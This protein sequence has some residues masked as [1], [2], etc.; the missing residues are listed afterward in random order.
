[1]TLP[2]QWLSNSSGVPGRAS[3]QAEKALHEF[4]RPHRL[5]QLRRALIFL[6]AVWAVLAITRLVW[7]LVP[8]GDLELDPSAVVV[9]PVREPAAAA[10]ASEVDIQQMISWQL[11]GEAGDEPLALVESEPE[12]AAA[13]REGIEEGARETRLELL[14]RGAVASTEDGR[15]HAIIE[16]RNTQ[17]VYAVEDKLP[18]SGNVVLAKVMPRQVVLDNGGTYEL[19]TLFEETTLDAQLP[20]ASQTAK[21]AQ[22]ATGAREEQRRDDPQTTAL[23]SDFRDRLYQD[24]QSLAEVVNVSAVRADGALQGYRVSPGKQQ[25]QF[26]QLGFKQGDLVTGINGIALDDPANTLSLYQTMRTAT[27]A[28]FELEREG[29]AISITVQLEDGASR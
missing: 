16:H 7:S 26:E 1:M 9:N 14:L 20:P 21:T 8:S 29:Q 13:S 3:A 2:A 23:A 6:L 10:A 15:G 4:S 18:V 24:P 28:V 17:A 12:A 25:Q 11:F 22:R 19:L 27:E 5:L